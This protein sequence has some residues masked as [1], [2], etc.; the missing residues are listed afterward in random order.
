MLYIE[1]IQ[2]FLCDFRQV[3]CAALPDLLFQAGEIIS[4]DQPQM[5][6]N[7]SL[8]RLLQERTCLSQILRSGEK[9]KTFPVSAHLA[10]HIAKTPM[11]AEDLPVLP[12]DPCP[13]GKPGDTGD[14]ADHANPEIGLI[15]PVACFKRLHFF[16][17]RF[18]NLIFLQPGQHGGCTA[19]K[20][21]V[22]RIGDGRIHDLSML[23][24]VVQDRT[25]FIDGHKS[26]SGNILRRFFKIV[27]DAPG[28]ENHF[29]LRKCLLRLLG[30]SLRRSDADTDQRKHPLL[31]QA[32]C[33]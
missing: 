28:S 25:A 4:V 3:L 30:H 1:D 17:M 7:S 33:R 2:A 31:T 18:L 19:V 12:G 16:P 11:G 29:R 14:P 32:A 6:Q 26:F 10:C 20:T 15:T 23:T 27:Q 8:L 5:A 24:K 22:T 9:Q 13:G 21:A